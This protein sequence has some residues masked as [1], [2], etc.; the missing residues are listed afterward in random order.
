MTFSKLQRFL[1]HSIRLYFAPLTGAYRGIRSE[2][3]RLDRIERRWAID[4]AREALA[5]RTNKEHLR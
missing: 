5:S 1:V 3:R 2:Y 4:D